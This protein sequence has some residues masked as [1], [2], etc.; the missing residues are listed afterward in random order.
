MDIDEGELQKRGLYDPDDPDAAG[1]LALLQHLARLGVTVEQMQGASRDSGLLD[2]AG[3]IRL[4]PGDL[5]AEDLSERTGLSLPELETV[6][7]WSGL[8]PRELK[9]RRFSD[10]DVV[11]L[12]SFITLSD[13]LDEDTAYAVL[14][15][16][17]GAFARM[18]DVIAVEYLRRVEPTHAQEAVSELDHAARNTQAI[19]SLGSAADGVASMFSHHLRWAL[20]RGRA[21]GDSAEIGSADMAVGFV[22]LVGY[23]TLSQNVSTAE[24]AELMERFETVAH[25]AVIARDGRVVKLIGDAVMFVAVDA[26]PACDIALQ[27]VEGFADP[28]DKV[29]PRGGI[30]VGDV[31]TRTGD[32]FGPIVNLA[33]RVADLAVAS[34]IL[35]T[36]DVRLRLEFGGADM[37]KTL[38]P[39]RASKYRLENAGRRTLKGFD[40]P[41]QLYTVTRAQP[42]VGGD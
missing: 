24:L 30:A 28:D 16:F 4:A 36:Q 31:L 21:A 27:L 32:F 9:E 29:K 35:V 3:H 23:T 1:R 19:V 26:E 15:V 22:D 40:A 10:A 38:G 5:T 7:K 8:P 39:G 33:S 20:R 34:E 18:A 41:V 11:M 37:S 25:E 6:W 42:T 12:L 2:L 13:M 17:G 14:R